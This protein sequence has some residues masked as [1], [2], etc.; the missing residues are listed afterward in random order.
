M[1]I[2]AA[3]LLQ[4]WEDGAGLHPVR[5]ALH[6]LHAAWPGVSLS[7]FGEASI[8]ERDAYLLTL[9]QALFGP[10]FT[11]VGLCPACRE[12]I[13]LNFRVEDIRAPA[14]G[15][16]GDPLEIALNGCRVWFRLPN[17]L[18]LLAVARLR[19]VDEARREL[20]LRCVLDVE[21]EAGIRADELPEPVE[22]ALIGQMEQA[23]PQ[24][25]VQ[26]ALDCPACSHHWLQ[27]FDILPYLW[28]EIDDWAGRTLHEVHLLASAHGWSERAILDMSAHRR[29]IYLDMV[30]T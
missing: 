29:R 5:M 1:D 22:A 12:P 17:S 25:N 18:D 9:R 27:P 23:D 4:A 24:A 6:L 21:S 26:L 30:L 19:T 14:P 28:Q 7:M 15:G 11:G 20:L 10:T 8:G 16:N 2:S 3:D 13:E